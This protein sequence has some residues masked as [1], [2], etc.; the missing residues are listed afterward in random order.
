MVAV[1]ISLCVFIL[2]LGILGMVWQRNKARRILDNISFMMDCVDNGRITDIK[3][4]D[5]MTK[6]ESR[7]G[8]YINAKFLAEQEILME[9]LNAAPMV[10][11]LQ[12]QM[13]ESITSLNILADL[14][15]K[16]VRLNDDVFT[17]CEQVQEGAEKLAQYMGA[18]LEAA[19]LNKSEIEVHAEAVDVALLLEEMKKTAA[20]LAQEKGVQL[21][22]AEAEIMVHM[23]MA[24]AQKALANIV[25]NAIK[26]TPKDGKVTV[27]CMRYES[28]CRIDVSDT[29]PG[30]PGE[31]QGYVFG[32]YW[33]A[34]NNTVEGGLG[35]GLYVARQLIQAQEG[36]IRLASI[37]GKG[38]TFSVFLPLEKGQQTAPKPTEAAPQ[39]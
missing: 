23:D 10:Q 24:L 11:D 29:G 28:N 34:P 15:Q 7:L 37:L 36:Y 2:A 19:H 31:Q 9:R 12:R 8:R 35:V 30:I 27:T 39:A 5:K 25:D 6:E 14:M 4:N 1:W 20:P 21:Q 17:L 18:L 13:R 26:Y 32:R 33:R 3:Y 16:Q 38:S 22:V